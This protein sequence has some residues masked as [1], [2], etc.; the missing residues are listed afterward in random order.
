MTWYVGA[1]A[2]LGMKPHFMPVGKAAPP[3]PRRFDFFTSSVI[4]AGSIWKARASAV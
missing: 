3:S 4:A 2:S 1:V